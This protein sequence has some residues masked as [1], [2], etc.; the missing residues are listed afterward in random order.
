MGECHGASVQAVPSRLGDWSPW[1]PLCRCQCPWGPAASVG[2]AGLSLPQGLGSGHSPGWSLGTPHW[3]PSRRSRGLRRRYPPQGARGPGSGEASVF[4]TPVA[5][6]AA[7]A[8]SR[9]A[10]APGRLRTGW[11]SE[12]RTASS[13]SP[14]PGKRDHR[15][16]PGGPR[17]PRAV[18][19]ALAPASPA[20]AGGTAEA[21]ARQA[22]RAAAGFSATASR[23]PGK[24]PPAPLPLPPPPHR[25]GRLGK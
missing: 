10:A 21:L 11:G 7:G 9:C 3:P 20:A 12:G 1:S 19:S 22:A 17:A 15:D 23:T 5:R 4:P 14:G 6:G 2:N 18:R 13:S 8:A 25:H 24:P 16:R